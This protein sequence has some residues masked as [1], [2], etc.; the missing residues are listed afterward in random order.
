MEN[1]IFGIV[2]FLGGIFFIFYSR[3]VESNKKFQIYALSFFLFGGSLLYFFRLLNYEMRIFLKNHFFPIFM[4]IF[5]LLLIV[6]VVV[7]YT[8]GTNEEKIDWK[9]RFKLVIFLAILASILIFIRVNY[10]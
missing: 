3:K 8:R 7:A 6:G 10:L 2:L 5:I 1:L 4:L 9:Y